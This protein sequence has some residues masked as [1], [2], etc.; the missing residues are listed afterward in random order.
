MEMIFLHVCRTAEI[1]DCNQLSPIMV[2]PPVSTSTPSS[3]LSN[4]GDDVT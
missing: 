4:L 1:I 3:R 2:R